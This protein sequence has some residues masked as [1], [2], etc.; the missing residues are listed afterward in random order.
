MNICSKFENLKLLLEKH[1]ESDDTTFSLVFIPAILTVHDVIALRTAS[2]WCDVVIAVC[3]DDKFKASQQKIL[4]DA[5]VDIL[6][7]CNLANA[8][9]LSLDSGEINSGFILKVILAVM[10]SAIVV[11]IA[12]LDLLKVILQIDDNYNEMFTPIYSETPAHILTESEQKIRQAIVSIKE[13]ILGG[14]RNI[15]IISSKLSDVLAKN[16]I[17]LSKLECVDN[18]GFSCK[19]TLENQQFFINVLAEIDN[20]SAQDGIQISL[21]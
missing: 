2:K 7:S 5:G 10:P 17:N 9:K 19:N 8:P 13:I 1:Q 15:E 3:L 18:K 14:E 6:L 21:S 16:N 11:Q 12:M 4:Q 20:V